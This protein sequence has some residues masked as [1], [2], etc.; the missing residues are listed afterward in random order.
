MSETARS[1][2]IRE[3][4]RYRGY[5]F[6]RK[7]VDYAAWRPGLGIF[8]RNNTGGRGRIRYGCPKSSDYLGIMP[9][10]RMLAVEAKDDGGELDDGQRQFRAIVLGCGG[11]YIEA[12]GI[13][14]V[15]REIRG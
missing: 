11:V 6:I 4:L 5:V 3:Y 1:A 2:I 12:R 7:E 13:E 14:D 15:E 10:G 9:D 8:W